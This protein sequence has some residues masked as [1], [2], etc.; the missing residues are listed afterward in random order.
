[1]PSAKPGT[2]HAREPPASGRVHLAE[3]RRAGLAWLTA[4]LERGIAE[5]DVP[6]GTDATALA[7][8]YTTVLHGLSIEARDGAERATLMAVVDRAMAAWDAQV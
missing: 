6:A 4:R 7:A 5:G 1:M 8:F 2:P 3:N